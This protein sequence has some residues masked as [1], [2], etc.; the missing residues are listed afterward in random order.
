MRLGYIQRA[1]VCAAKDF[2]RNNYLTYAAALAFFF[3]LSLF[4]L[5]IFMASA[6]TLVPLPNLFDQILELMARVVPPDAM[7]VVQGVLRDILRG[8]TSLLSLGILG[9]IWAASGGFAAMIGAIN[10]AY[11]VR[12]G[13]PYWKKRL[14]AIGLTVLVGCMTVVALTAMVLG[15]RFG[16]WLAAHVNLSPVFAAVWPYLRWTAILAFTVLSVETLFY[17]APNVRQRFWAQFPGALV[18][19]VLWLGA[20]YGLGRYLSSFADFNKTYG[21]LGAAVALML[22]FYITALAVLIGAELN[23]ELIRARGEFVKVKERPQGPSPEDE[24][25]SD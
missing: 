2:V 25:K 3:L 12:E 24:L 13:R 9:A 20:S 14:V 7:G 23:A 16:E 11:D 21:T 18:T 1:L 17:F 8:G 10:V 5:L 22:W 19:V 6:L 4:P 15:P